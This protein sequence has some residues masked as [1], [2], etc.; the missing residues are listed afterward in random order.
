M[1]PLTTVI[2]VLIGMVGPVLVP[3]ASLAFHTLAPL[4]MD[5]ETGIF[6]V[7]ILPGIIWNIFI[8]GTNFC[9]LENHYL[10]SFQATDIKIY[11]IK[12]VL[13]EYS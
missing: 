4:V 13:L 12:S 8:L 7:A 9:G 10:I 3:L 2:S 1:Y 11:W 6:T 5:H